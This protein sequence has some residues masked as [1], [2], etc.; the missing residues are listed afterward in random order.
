M[1]VHKDA[2][3]K[4]AAMKKLH[5]TI[6]FQ[7][8]KANEAHKRKIN[9]HRKPSIFKPGDLVWV[10]L[11]KERFPSKRRSKLA[12]RAD[13]PFEVLERVND[14]AYKVNVPDKM[15]GVSATFNIG[16]LSPYMEDSHLED[17]RASPS[18]LG[19]MMYFRPLLQL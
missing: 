19:G 18:Q 3:E 4:A 9:K 2:K 10:H 15:G 12:P 11:R 14:N 13:G 16:D 5:E 17:L 6:K 7:I 1:Q 8:M